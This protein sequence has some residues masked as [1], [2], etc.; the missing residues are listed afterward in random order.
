MNKNIITIGAGHG[1]IDSGA[2]GPTGL[3]E[4]DCTL[5]IALKTAELLSAVPEFDVH[6]LRSTDVYIGL[7]ERGRMA[8]RL[9]SR[10]HVEVHVNAFNGKASYASVWRSV[11]LPGDETD[12]D[13]MSAAIAQA[14]GVKSTG[15][16][17]KNGVEHPENDYFT[18]IETAYRGGVP[19]IFLPECGF[20]DHA[21]TEAKLRQQETV[22]VLAKAIAQSICGI[23]GVSLT[24]P[25]APAPT[26]QPIEG[27]PQTYEV[28]TTL[29]G[30]LTADEALG[31]SNPK[32]TV[33]P[34]KY[35]VF[36]RKG[37]AVNV[38]LSAGVPGSWINA[39]LNVKAPATAQTPAQAPGGSA[40]G[41]V[42][43][44]AKGS[45]YVRE[46]P[47]FT[48]KI[49]GIVTGGQKYTVVPAALNFKKIVYNGNAGYVGPAAWEK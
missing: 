31:G 9:G 23:F 28:V 33:K 21:P 13:K 12:A 46:K 3:K 32:G 49:L 39:A 42:L 11:H 45:Y 30:Y 26:S 18:V 43:T 48:S 41:T 38:T 40:S 44:V 1:G 15:S 25:S 16:Q 14:L 2:V 20:I 10:C 19:H 36:N 27:P 35:T 34:G 37:E 5:A 17:T 22:N 4:K 24:A 47:D 29:R 6:L 8:S 7:A